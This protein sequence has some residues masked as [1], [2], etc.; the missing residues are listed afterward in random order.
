MQWE[1]SLTVRRNE[2]LTVPGQISNQLYWIESGALRA[3][4]LSENQEQTLRLGYPQSMI[5]DLPSLLSG[6]P[7]EVHIQA[8][9]KTTVKPLSKSALEKIIYSGEHHM[10]LYISMMEEFMVQQVDREL[11]ILTTSPLER[12]QRC[13]NRS[14]QLFQHIP[15]RHIAAY[16]NMSEETLSRLKKNTPKQNS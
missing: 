8:L 13:L 10:R 11:D 1:P 4:F 3:Y 15:A 6:K 14:P 2:H 16:L 5:A 7:S 12:Y 9:K